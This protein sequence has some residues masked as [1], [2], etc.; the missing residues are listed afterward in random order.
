ML[1][2]V[3][4]VLAEAAAATPAA[5]PSPGLSLEVA[6]NLAMERSKDL[7][8]ALLAMEAATLAPERLDGA[9]DWAAFAEGGVSR[10]AAPRT[11]P[12]E[13]ET[14][15]TVPLSAGL[16]R[17]FPV[18]TFLDVETGASYFDTPFPETGF[19]ISLLES[20]VRQYTR[21]T[22]THPLWGSTPGK[23]IRL[24]QTLIAEN[25]AAGAAQAAEGL[26]QVLTGIH[27]GFWGW[28]MAVE[29]L[30]NANEA[31]KA[32]EEI[33][34]QVVRK[35]RRGLA[36]E[37]D[38][39]RAAAAVQQAL[40]QRLAAEWIVDQARRAFLDVVGAPGA[41]EFASY[42]LDAPVPERS[43]E[44][45]VSAAFEASLGLRA[46]ENRRDAQH[47][48]VALSDERVKPRLSA[49]AR[50]REDALFPRGD[51]FD[52][53]LGFTTFLGLRFDKTFG[54]AEAN[55]DRR[56]ARL[57]LRRIDAEIARKRERIRTAAAEQDAAIA[58]ARARVLASQEL[59]GIQ[60]ARLREEQRNF[61]IGRAVLRD[62]IEARQQ[63][64]GAKFLLDA[65]RVTLRMAAEERALLAGDL[66]GK[67]RDRLARDYPAYRSVLPGAG[68]HQRGDAQEGIAP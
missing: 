12:F 63:V 32:A 28:V 5:S 25:A 15:T 65:A 42:D 24:Q 47:L 38:R 50:L 19:P 23:T 2:L 64:T 16:S 59:V 27:R 4:L 17:L 53:D 11:S 52:D 26:D 46:L 68:N 49:V 35:L 13:P 60:E 41:Y 62:L 29:A 6:V 58:S 48:V 14:I 8:A 33:R 10:D 31:V 20:G 43:L 22:A 34:D 57:E 30:D 56:Q 44:E 21:V 51:D 3:P 61:D 55:V 39:L 37:R 7:E 18:G 1:L 45:V 66:T 54:N 67:W 40:D 9:Y 36:D